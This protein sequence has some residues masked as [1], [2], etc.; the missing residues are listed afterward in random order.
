MSLEHSPA[1]SR[2][3]GGRELFDPAKAYSPQQ[4]ADALSI[5]RITVWK[6]IRAGRLPKTVK[7]GPFTSRLLGSELNECLFGD[8]SNG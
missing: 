7:V 1:G 8:A 5:H 6:L 2:T 3:R 4:V